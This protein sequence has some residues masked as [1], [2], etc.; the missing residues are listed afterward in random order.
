M[1][2]RASPTKYSSG[3]RVGMLTLVEYKVGSFWLCKCDCGEETTVVTGNLTSGNTRS[4][5][6][7][8]KSSSQ[9]NIEKARLKVLEDRRNKLARY[10]ADAIAAAKAAQIE[11]ELNDR[12]KISEARDL[13]AQDRPI[14]LTK[15]E[16]EKLEAERRAEAA[17]AAPAVELFNI[18]TKGK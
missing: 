2:K 1:K 5:G 10:S 17:R 14:R 7:Q 4:C 11:R 18:W 6:C 8:M 16:Q 15:R 9:K 3:D 13:K 12:R